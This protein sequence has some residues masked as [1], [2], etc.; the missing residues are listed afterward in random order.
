MAGK[1]VLQVPTEF[2]RSVKKDEQFAIA[3]ARAMLRQLA[4]EL[5]GGDLGWVSLLDVGCGV[6][7][8][9]VL[10]NDSLPI[11]RY[12]GVDVYRP[13]IEF[14]AD[15]VDDPR[16]EYHHVDFHNERY[17]PGGTKMTAS[18]TLPVD[19]GAFDL[20]TLY[21][22]FTHLDP[23]DY[24]A[25]LTMLRRYVK[26]DGHA[27][28]SIFLDQLS[29]AGHGLMDN[30]VR[31]MGPKS[32][33]KTVGYRDLSPEGSPLMQALYTEAHAR[34]LIEGTGWKLDRILE[35]TT[36]VQYQF[37]VSPITAR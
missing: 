7:F 32:V 16:F 35:P 27:V 26:P 29:Q 8:T 11:G 14:L 12:V 19:E 1:P 22:V 36:Y 9:Q 25:M 30:W 3:S 34:S 24:V 10:V 31:K 4:D 20:I 6:K 33:G 37:V 18:S 2:Q 28:Y 17:N 13:M 5:A 15:N 23:E 21:S